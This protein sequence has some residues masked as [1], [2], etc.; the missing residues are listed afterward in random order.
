MTGDDRNLHLIYSCV[1]ESFIN[2]STHSIYS[3]LLNLNQNRIGNLIYVCVSMA[4]PGQR[5]PYIKL[6]NEQESTRATRHASVFLLNWT[7]TKAYLH[8]FL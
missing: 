6:V 1:K 5:I 4:Y 3:T 2:R 8:S 7:Q